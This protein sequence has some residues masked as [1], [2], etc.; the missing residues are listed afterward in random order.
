MIDKVFEKNKPNT[1]FD[2]CR[3]W[4]INEFVIIMEV[5]Q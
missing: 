5:K 3:S 2:I 4:K 1:G